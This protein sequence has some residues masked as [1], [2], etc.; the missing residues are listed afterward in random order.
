[1]YER[2]MVTAVVDDEVEGRAS[3]YS[4]TMCC[5]ADSSN[6]MMTIV[7]GAGG[8][9]VDDTG[10]YFAEMCVELIERDEICCLRHHPCFQNY[11]TVKEDSFIIE[12]V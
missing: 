2:S 4:L 10:S 1:M 9:G 8:A 12:L 6:L 7:G 11:W 3:Y 5:Y